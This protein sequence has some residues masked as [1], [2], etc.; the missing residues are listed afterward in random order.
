MQKIIMAS[1]MPYMWPF[2][3][4]LYVD[5]PKHMTSKGPAQV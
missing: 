2:T 4:Y 1:N 5:E 3:I